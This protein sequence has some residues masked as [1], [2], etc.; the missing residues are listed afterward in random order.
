MCPVVF[1]LCVFVSCGGDVCLFVCLCVFV[2]VCVC[3][4]MCVS[5]CVCACMCVCV[6]EG[7]EWWFD[8]GVVMGQRAIYLQKEEGLMECVDACVWTP[9]QTTQHNTTLHDTTQHSMTQHHNHDT[10]RKRSTLQSWAHAV[11]VMC[12][13][14]SLRNSASHKKWKN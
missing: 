3:L 13:G 8:L 6:R 14:R 12:A 2:H 7:E 5:V 4:C 10:W 9:H 1:V 11:V